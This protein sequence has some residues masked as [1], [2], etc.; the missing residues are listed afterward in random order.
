M[1]WLVRALVVI[2]FALVGPI[3]LAPNRQPQIMNVL[4]GLLTGSLC[5]LLSS[6]LGNLG[7]KISA[8]HPIGAARAGIV[9][10]CIGAAMAALSFGLASF[11]AAVAGGP[12]EFVVAGGSGAF[13]YWAAGWGLHRALTDRRLPIERPAFALTPASGS[14]PRQWKIAFSFAI[15]GALVAPFAFGTYKARPLYAAPSTAQEKQEFANTQSYC[16]REQ[17][18]EQERERQFALLGLEEDR[19]TIMQKIMRKALCD[20]E[21]DE[22]DWSGEHKYHFDR[23]KYLLQNIGIAIISF[24]SVFVLAF[25]IPMSVRGSAFV[26]RRYWQWLND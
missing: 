12:L 7:R 9:F 2:A 1:V 25:L 20:V 24:I 16:Q 23:A 15:V 4:Q 11:F 8:R 19:G 13:L 3:M 22:F 6:L 18:R 21:M 26:V 5:V 17:E 14:R 10:Y